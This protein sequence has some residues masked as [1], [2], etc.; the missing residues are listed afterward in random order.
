IELRER[1]R[2]EQRASPE[3]LVHG[4]IPERDLADAW[5]AALLRPVKEPFP[6]TDLWRH[7]E[8]RDRLVS[9]FLAVLFL[10]R[11]NVIELREERLG[12][13][14]LLLV[15]VAEVRPTRDKMPE[16]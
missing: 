9:L 8:G 1:L 10:A 7:A 6:L 15:R 2:D 16:A 4:D 11:E 5:E 13:S 12:E 3:V 14:P